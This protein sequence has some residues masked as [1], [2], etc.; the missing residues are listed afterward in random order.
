[1]ISGESPVV[2]KLKLYAQ[3]CSSWLGKCRSFF[4]EKIHH[5]DKKNKQFNGSLL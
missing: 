3:V 4:Y 2:N 5:S 1:M